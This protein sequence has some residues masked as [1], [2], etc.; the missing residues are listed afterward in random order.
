MQDRIDIAAYL[1]QQIPEA[2]VYADL[3]DN[4]ASLAYG[5]HPERLYVLLDDKVAYQGGMGPFFYDLEELTDWLA[6]FNTSNKNNN[7]IA[8]M[9]INN[10]NNNNSNNIKWKW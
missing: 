10:N 6:G 8:T 4:A 7:N 3:F 1:Q 5:A 2:Q 9:N